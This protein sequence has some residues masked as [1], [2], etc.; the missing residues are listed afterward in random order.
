AFLVTMSAQLAGVIA[1]ARVT[2]AVQEELRT[3]AGG[4]ARINGI[5]GAPGIAIGTAV[6]VSPVA[7]LYAVPR[8]AAASRRQELRAFKTALAAVRNDIEAVSENLRGEMSPE[9]HA[10]F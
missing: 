6:V 4:P 9:D 2:G 3:G 5:A 8:K 10:L 7:D 1:H